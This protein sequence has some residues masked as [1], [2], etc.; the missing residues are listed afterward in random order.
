[1]HRLPGRP[2]AGQ[3][4]R[5]PRPLTTSRR[6]RRLPRAAVMA[7]GVRRQQARQR[8]DQ[9]PPRRRFRARSRGSEQ[10]GLH[11]ARDRGRRRPRRLLRSAGTGHRQRPA[12][13]RAI[14][15]SRCEA[16]RLHVRRRRAQGP[17]VGDGR[18]SQRLR[19]LARPS[20][21]PP[22]DDPGQRRHR[23]GVRARLAAEPLGRPARARDVPAEGSGRRRRP[24][25]RAGQR[26]V[27]AIVAEPT[28]RVPS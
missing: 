22:G 1:M 16:V 24:A 10:Q 11:Q 6:D 7:A 23:P 3:Q 8:G 27:V 19:G 12:S 17:A 13:E 18:P 9:V 26:M 5:L 14:H 20:G 21:R 4:A 2:R 25:S 15:L 28:T